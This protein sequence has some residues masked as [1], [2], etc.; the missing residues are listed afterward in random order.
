MTETA[1]ASRVESF[2]HK[3]HQDR[4]HGRSAVGAVVFHDKFP[5]WKR[6]LTKVFGKAL[7]C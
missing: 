2:V 6:T 7:T 4:P 3:E 1:R 5:S